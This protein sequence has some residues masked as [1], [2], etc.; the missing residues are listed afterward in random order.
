MHDNK[1]DGR[2]HGDGL[3]RAERVL[4]TFGRHICKLGW[5]KGGIMKKIGS[6]VACVFSV[7]APDGMMNDTTAA[8]YLWEQPL[9]QSSC[10]P[11]S[12]GRSLLYIDKN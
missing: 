4:I 2:G 9:D 8:Y 12:E 3:S 5:P 6:S 11:L 1:G 7:A 10:I